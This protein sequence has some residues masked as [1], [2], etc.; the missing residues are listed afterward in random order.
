MGS[1]GQLL[2]YPHGKDDELAGYVP[3]GTIAIQ[4]V[5]EHLAELAR[6]EQQYSH[7]GRVKPGHGEEF[8]V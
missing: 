2:G 5:L 7:H 4:T 6:K 1:L 8:E 3:E